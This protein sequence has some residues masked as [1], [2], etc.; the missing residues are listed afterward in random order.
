MLT[1]EQR[2][3]IQTAAWVTI[4]TAEI[5]TTNLWELGATQPIR[6]KDG[7]TVLSLH[8]LRINAGTVCR[9]TIED[10]YK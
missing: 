5:L 7:T 8:A 3:N 1:A 10:H 4:I 2:K 6:Y 9:R